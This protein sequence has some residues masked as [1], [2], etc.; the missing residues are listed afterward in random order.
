MKKIKSILAI[1]IVLVIGVC[2]TG[3]KSNDYEAAVSLYD[4]GDYAAAMSAFAE[5]GDYKDSAERAAEAKQ[6]DDYKAAAALYDNGDY[7][8]AAS[9]FAE[10]G[11]Y[12]DS[13]DRAA[14]IKNAGNAEFSEWFSGVTAKR[15]ITGSGINL[16][17]QT[18]DYSGKNMTSVNSPAI[19]AIDGTEKTDAGFSLTR[20]AIIGKP[21][22][23]LYNEVIGYK[24]PVVIIRF[25]DIT[26]TEY[27]SLTVTIEDRNNAEVTL[28]YYPDVE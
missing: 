11:D 17:L 26:D 18:T 24:Q 12:K 5:L 20:E 10:L 8:A 23:G 3:C 21:S 28:T 2:L 16:S 22:G 27:D 13:A 1:V 15:D 25:D 6:A 7:P 4:S 19:L 9:A 14:E